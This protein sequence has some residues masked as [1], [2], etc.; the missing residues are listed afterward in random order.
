MGINC[1]VLGQHLYILYF[2]FVKN[3]TKKVHVSWLILTVPNQHTLYFCFPLGYGFMHL[4]LAS[5]HQVYY[6]IFDDDVTM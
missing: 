6:F 4:R 2:T 1:V 3:H 5:S